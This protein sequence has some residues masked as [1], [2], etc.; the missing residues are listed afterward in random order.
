VL[1]GL[2]LGV[3]IGMF[4][5]ELTVLGLPNRTLAGILLSGLGAWDDSF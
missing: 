4:D 3:G 1:G 5:E 2:G